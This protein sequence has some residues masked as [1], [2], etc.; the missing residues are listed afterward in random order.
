MASNGDA[1][2]DSSV[3]VSGPQTPFIYE[4]KLVTTNEWIRENITDDFFGKIKRYLISIF[5]I[6]SWIYRYNLTWAFG[7]KHSLHNYNR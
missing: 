7:G 3:E 2:L 4:T 6:F 5:P 1:K